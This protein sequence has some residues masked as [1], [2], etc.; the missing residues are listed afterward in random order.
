MIDDR[1]IRVG[2]ELDGVVKYFEKVNIKASGSKTNNS[3]QNEFNISIT[4]LSRETRD[5]LLT[6]NNILNRK[7]KN[8]SITVEAGR[9]STGLS[10]VFKGD[11]RMVNTS[12]PPNIA[13]NIRTYTGDALKS[14][15]ISTSAGASA[16]LSTISKTIAESLSKKLIFQAIDK[17][18]AN[19][20]FTGAKLEQVK[21]IENLGGV[22]VTID[23]DSMIVK[24]E[25]KPLRGQIFL[26][27]AT[28]GMIGLPTINERGISVKTLFNNNVKIGSIIR[29]ESK[30]NVALN[31]DYVVYEIHYDIANRD[32]PFYTTF[33]GTKY[34]S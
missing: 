6:N 18:I 29:I 10:L 11:I 9:K 16:K 26:I 12:Q 24:N 31:G 8:K 13:L 21:R 25:N 28:N 5:Y 20:A 7:L 4:N 27:N 2:I 15:L 22:D 1:I 19:Y 32:T 17:T 33:E 23:N 30:I 3:T 34:E 14:Q